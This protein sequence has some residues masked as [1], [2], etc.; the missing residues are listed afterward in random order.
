MPAAAGEAQGLSSSGPTLKIMACLRAR[1]GTWRG[2][3][4]VYG[5]GLENQRGASLRGFE[6]HPL[7]L[8][9]VLRRL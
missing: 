9:K 4:V 6:S 3:R 5:S 1:A 8:N 7:R 2:G